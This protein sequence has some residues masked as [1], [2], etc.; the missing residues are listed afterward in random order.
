MRR[1]WTLAAAFFLAGCAGPTLPHAGAAACGRL[2]LVADPPDFAMGQIVF[3][4]ERFVNCGDQA[5]RVVDGWCGLRL[6]GASVGVLSEAGLQQAP[7]PCEDAPRVVLPGESF[8]RDLAWDG[9]VHPRCGDEGCP[10][11]QPAPAGRWLAQAKLASLDTNDAWSATVDVRLAAWT[12][13]HGAWAERHV[14]WMQGAGAFSWRGGVVDVPE[15]WSFATDGEGFLYLEDARLDHDAYGEAR[16]R[17]AGPPGNGTW[18]LVGA[19]SCAWAPWPGV[20]CLA[21]RAPEACR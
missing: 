17:V 14:E 13:D 10:A 19:A 7:P 6:E 20:L 9:W 18:A 4:R 11:S 8:A 21:A 3:L 15:G 16:C 2:S 1:V 5:L 12:E